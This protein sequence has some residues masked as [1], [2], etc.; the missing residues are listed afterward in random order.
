MASLAGGQPSTEAGRP[1]DL[2]PSRSR[3]RGSYAKL[4][5][6]QT[7]SYVPLPMKQITYLHEEPRVVWEEEEITQMKANEQLEY[8]V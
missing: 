3:S 7:S 4:L 2:V 6:L 8:A 5:Q 1:P